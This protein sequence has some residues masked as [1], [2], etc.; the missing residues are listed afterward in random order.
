MFAFAQ[1]PPTN[2]GGHT[3]N[4]QNQK[5][6]FF[7]YELANNP[8][9]NGPSH[10]AY[11]TIDTHFGAG[12]PTNNAGSGRDQSSGYS[13]HK[14][15]R[16]MVTGGHEAVRRTAQD[17]AALGNNFMNTVSSPINGGLNFGS[18]QFDFHSGPNNNNG[19]NYMKV[20]RQIIN[21]V[22]NAARHNAA[23]GNNF[24]KT[25]FTP[26][27]KQSG[28][29][30]NI[31]IDQ[32]SRRFDFHN[33]VGQQLQKVGHLVDQTEENMADSID[34]FGKRVHR[35]VAAVFEEENNDF[36]KELEDMR[37]PTNPLEAVNY[38]L[39]MMEIILMHAVSTH[40]SLAHAWK[41]PRESATAGVYNLNIKRYLTDLHMSAAPEDTS[42]ATQNWSYNIERAILHFKR[43]LEVIYNAGQ[44]PELNQIG[45][46]NQTNRISKRPQKFGVSGNKL[47]SPGS[48]F[49]LKLLRSLP[50][51]YRDA[52]NRAIILQ[53]NKGTAHPLPPP[54]AAGP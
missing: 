40:R 5:E 42:D 52:V 29:G 13:N 22:H 35:S 25:V 4:L 31:G 16:Q 53:Y 18:N 19:R 23:H 39:L 8:L 2:T 10:R 37:P 1:L 6:Q 15:I 11:N 9:T 48:D 14:T 3:A 28:S 49:V 26:P 47:P 34:T 27:T 51:D 36:A 20:G 24:V 50:A 30:M 7:P 21:T 46:T 17:V 38:W 43:T 33:E 45:K 44:R 12:G 41:G 54:H 32:S